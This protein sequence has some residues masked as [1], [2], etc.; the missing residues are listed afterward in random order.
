MM[1]WRSWNRADRT[2]LLAA[3]F[4]GMI[5]STLTMLFGE[6]PTNLKPV[7]LSPAVMVAVG[8]SLILLVSTGFYVPVWLDALL[9]GAVVI[10]G[11]GGRG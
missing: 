2:L 10:V 5:Y 6:P 1:V 11:G 8:L 4:A 9:R 7:R 3:V